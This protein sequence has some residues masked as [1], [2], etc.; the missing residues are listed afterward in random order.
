MAV[1]DDLLRAV[2][3]KTAGRCHICHKRVAFSRYGVISARS[4]WEIDHSVPRAKGGT[5]H[6]N[7]LFPAHISCNRSKQDGGT[8]AARADFGKARAP[9]SVERR[10]RA[11]LWTAVGGALT[12]GATGFRFAGPPGFLA[13]VIV[14]GIIG[15]EMDPENLL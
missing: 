13:G 4:G 9:M 1:N 12:A 6:P 14:G 10:Q 3:N 15:Y 2:F 7:N 8:R 5:D 11:K